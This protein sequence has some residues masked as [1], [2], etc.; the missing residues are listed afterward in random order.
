MGD[1]RAT[2]AACGVRYVR[3]MTTPDPDELLTLSEAAA[4]LTVSKNTV[5]RLERAGQLTAVRPT[6]RTVRYRRADI[7]RRLAP[8]T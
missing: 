8:A 4:L 2:C 5:L 3:V 6:P 7:E 1:I